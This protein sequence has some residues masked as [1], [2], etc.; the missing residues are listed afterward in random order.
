MV[1]DPNEPTP[2]P[3]TNTTTSY[4]RDIQPLIERS[5][6]SC[7]TQGGVAPIPLDTPE[8][9]TAVA[10]ALFNAIEQNRMPPFFASAACR[11]WKGDNRLSSEEKVL[12]KQW[13]DE[14]SPRGDPSEERHATQ[15]PLPT[16]RHDL[17]MTLGRFDV[18]KMNDLDNYH[19]FSLD[20][21]NPR[22]L[23][24]TGYEVTPGNIAVVHHVLAYV[25]EPDQIAKLEQLDAQDPR[26]GYSCQSASVGIPGTIQRQI[27]SWVPGSLPSRMP[28][29]SA[30]TLAANSRI[31][32]QVHYSLNALND[33]TVSPWDETKL[34]FEIATGGQLREARVLPM[35]KLNLSIPP[36]ESNSVQVGEFP[37]LGPF[38][39]A[40][41]YAAAAHAHQ[42]ASRIRLEVLRVGGE[43]E[44]VMDNPNW[45][46]NWQRSYEMVEPVKLAVGDRFRITCTYDN[47]AA[48]Q[49]IIN[50]VQKP[51]TEVN[52]GESSYDEMCMTYLTFVQ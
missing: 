19:C 21:K 34:A 50:G 51:P 37:A 4:L 20:P 23:Q 33:P 18:T 46:F 29:S 11:S 26:P 39:G 41:L 7:H 17:E 38:R 22:D 9:V 40:T 1:L 8:Q 10:A 36:G 6:Q 44:C 48:N 43:T 15:V 14:G 31:V 27:A 5:C 32:V 12:F 13:I 24:I 2:R 45:D 42:L 28:E 25:V 47:S 52:W 16:V 49:P 30:L 35:V 3:E